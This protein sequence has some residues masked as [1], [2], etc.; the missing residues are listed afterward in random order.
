MTKQ[1]KKELIERIKQIERDEKG[2]NK[3]AGEYLFG[4][5][6]GYKDLNAITED[7]YHEVYYLIDKKVGFK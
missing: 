4:L 1:A 2:L 6:Q 7:E 3:E 5:T